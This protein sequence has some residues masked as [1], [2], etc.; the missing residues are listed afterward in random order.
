MRAAMTTAIRSS[1]VTGLSR[2]TV[3]ATLAELA[4]QRGPTSSTLTPR[5]R[6]PEA[7]MLRRRGG[8]FLDRSPFTRP[9]ENTI[10]LD[11]DVEAR[12]QADE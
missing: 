4:T 6:K 11:R 3:A 2:A 5:R 1:P 7:E 12:A 9:A 10:D 8:A